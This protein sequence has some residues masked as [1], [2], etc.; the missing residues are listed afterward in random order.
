LV[1]VNGDVVDPDRTSV[2]ARLARHGGNV[3][4]ASGRRR[5][6]GRLAIGRL[7]GLLTPEHQISIWCFI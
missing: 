6:T 1:L 5:Q 3:V 4:A 7:G 2:P